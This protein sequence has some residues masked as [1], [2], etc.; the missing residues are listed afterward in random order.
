MSFPFPPYRRLWTPS[1]RR[2]CVS[3]PMRPSRQ[4]C[5]MVLLRFL[6]RALYPIAVLIHAFAAATVVAFAATPVLA[7]VVIVAFMTVR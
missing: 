6:D 5:L 2:G 7:T 4:A 3:T 1:T